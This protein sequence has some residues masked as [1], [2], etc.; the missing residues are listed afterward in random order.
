MT[1]NLLNVIMQLSAFNNILEYDDINIELQLHSKGTEN[2]Y[3]K[4]KDICI[5]KDEKLC[6]TFSTDIVEAVKNFTN[7]FKNT[8]IYDIIL[9]FTY[10]KKDDVISNYNFK[11]PQNSEETVNMLLNK[12]TEHW[13]Q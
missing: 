1:K 12:L 11:I 5:K 13:V 8:N 7:N 10:I 9:H 3:F 4:L 2:G 6:S